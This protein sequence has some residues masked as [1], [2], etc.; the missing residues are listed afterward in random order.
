MSNS[1]GGTGAQVHDQVNLRANPNGLD[2]RN[3]ANGLQVLNQVNIRTNHDGPGKGNG[4]TNLR[5]LDQ[6]MTNWNGGTGTQIANQFQNDVAPYDE[7]DMY[8]D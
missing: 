1:N 2:G 6:Y 7:G 4:S 3:G 5:D 8:G